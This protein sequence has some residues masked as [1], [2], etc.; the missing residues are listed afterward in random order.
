MSSRDLEKKE[1]GGRHIAL[2]E[3]QSPKEREELVSTWSVPRTIN[4]FRGQSRFLF[5][6]NLS[7][8]DVSNINWRKTIF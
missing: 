8:L 2:G 5:I 3:V 7:G 6:L 1:G 4:Q